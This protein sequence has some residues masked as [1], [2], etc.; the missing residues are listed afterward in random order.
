MAQGQA[1]SSGA[2]CAAS[3]DPRVERTQGSSVDV[4]V[5]IAVCA[6]LWGADAWVE[7]AE[8]SPAK[9]AWLATILAAPG[10]WPRR[11]SVRERAPP[12][13]TTW[14][15]AAATGRRRHEAADPTPALRR[16]LS[17]RVGRGGALV[18]AAKQTLHQGYEKA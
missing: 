3:E 8:C 12:G 15:Q 4:S 17:R 10:C 1:H 5:A 9:A 7:S 13:V 6:V 14:G 11:S 18:S 2:C 16:C